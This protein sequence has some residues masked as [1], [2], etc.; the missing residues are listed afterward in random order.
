MALRFSPERLVV[1]LGL[2]ALGIVG[3]LARTGALDFL[4]TV[5]MLSEYPEIGASDG[6][7][8]PD[9]P[10]FYGMHDAAAT[11]VGG[12]LQ[13]MEHLLAGERAHAFH[14]GGGLHHAFPARASGF[15]VYNDLAVSIRRARTAGHR[16]LYVDI[17]VHHGDGVESIFWN[18][19]TSRP[20]PSTRRD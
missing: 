7:E 16:V 14:P 1:G 19:P 3:T 6:F 4:A 12:T 13:A 10:P 15:C 17:D 11:V 2:V 18:D 5:R 8:G 9:T 20:C